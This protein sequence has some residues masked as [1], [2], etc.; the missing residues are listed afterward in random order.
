MSI[1]EATGPRKDDSPV[2]AL[3]I[4]LARNDLTTFVRQQAFDAEQRLGFSIRACADAPST[5]Q[6][7][8]GA[9]VESQASGEPLAVSNLYCA[10]SVYLNPRDNVLFRFWHDTSHVKL[11]VSFALDD[12]LEL[13][14]WHLEQC[15]RAGFPTGSLP[16]MVLHADLVGQIQLMGLIGR[17]PINQRR[18]VT[19]CIEYGFET[20]LLEEIRRI[21][22]PEAPCQTR[23]DNLVTR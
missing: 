15:T 11:G 22:E 1:N 17:F 14:L 21:P 9:Y 20:G 12:E 7:L 5:Y 8:R 2:L 16:W 18:F 3:E 6:Q 13:A 23:S 19:E 10:D 4:V